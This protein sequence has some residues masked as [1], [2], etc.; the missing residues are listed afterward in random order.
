MYVHTYNT[1]EDGGIFAQLARGCRCIVLLS[2]PA[3]QFGWLGTKEGRCL[4]F[5]HKVKAPVSLQA[6]HHDHLDVPDRRKPNTSKE[7]MEAQVEAHYKL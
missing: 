4:E 2:S 7:P 1:Y 5:K 3:K 6:P